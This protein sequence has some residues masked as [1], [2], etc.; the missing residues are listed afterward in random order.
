MQHFAAKLLQ[1]SG[2]SLYVAGMQSF[3]SKQ[4]DD[5]IPSSSAD[6]RSYLQIEFVGRCRK[7]PKYSIR[8]FARSLGVHS[9]TLSA[10][11]SGKRKLSESMV[12]LLGKKL[13]LSPSEID[14]FRLAIRHTDENHQIQITFHQLSQDSFVSISEWYH[15][16]ILELTRLPGFLPESKWIAGRLSISVVEANAALERL[17]R[18]GLLKIQDIGTWTASYENDTNILDPDFSSVAMRK[19]QKQVLELST[20][21]LEEVPKTLRDHTS[22]TLAIR[23][24]DI[25][26]IKQ[27]IKKFRYE[28]ASYCQRPDVD[29]DEVYQLSVSFFPLT[30]HKKENE[31]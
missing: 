1:E 2:S 25:H 5:G 4:L 15:D 9:G 21:A 28:L 23:K 19:Y 12:Q 6:F 22:T 31:K 20:I 29:P 30:R 10:I 18:L 26:E 24:A 8:A 13:G 7:N 14:Q 3:G 17:K 11:L 27:K 16:A